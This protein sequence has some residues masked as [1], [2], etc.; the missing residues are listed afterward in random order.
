MPRVLIQIGTGATP[1]WSMS[2]YYGGINGAPLDV[3][4]SMGL[5]TLDS[6][7]NGAG[8][9]FSAGVTRLAPQVR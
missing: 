4:G 2:Y 5:R 8:A 6:S 7:G 3:N 9:Y 1:G